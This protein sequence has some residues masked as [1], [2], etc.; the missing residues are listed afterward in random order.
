MVA[1]FEE[2]ASLGLGSRTSTQDEESA[3][4][5]IYIPAIYSYSTAVPS[6]MEL[7]RKHC[8]T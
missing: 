6:F 5:S 8:E 3:T 7:L 1:K 4:L 2:R